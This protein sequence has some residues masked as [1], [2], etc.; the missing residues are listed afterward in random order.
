MSLKNQ[1]INLASIS[2]R[3]SV[4]SACDLSKDRT[5]TVPGEGN[6][7]AAIMF[8]GEAPGF[9]ED[10]TGEPFVGRAGSLLTDLLDTIGLKR[11]DVYITNMVKCRPPKNRDPNEAEIDSCSGHLDSQILTVNPIVIVTL[12]RFSFGKFFPRV[13]IS[14]ARGKA[15]KWK[16]KIVFPMYHPAAALYNP[17]LRPRLEQDFQKLNEFIPNVEGSPKKPTDP[18]TKPKQLGF[19]D[20]R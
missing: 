3:V 18:S 15:K 5:N 13:P 2:Q 4:C 6:P 20:I 1:H 8:I 9:N 16:G 7:N 10:K 17:S 12:G 14:K 11:R 19:F